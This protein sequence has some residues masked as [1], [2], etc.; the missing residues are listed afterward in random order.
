[1]KLKQRLKLKQNLR[2]LKVYS[3]AR[4]Y[5]S[6]RD[7]YLNECMLKHENNYLKAENSSEMFNNIFG[8]KTIPTDFIKDDDKIINDLIDKNIEFKKDLD[9]LKISICELDKYSVIAFCKYVEFNFHILK[10][11][12]N[13]IYQSQNLVSYVSKFITKKQFLQ[14]FKEIDIFTGDKKVNNLFY[15][16]TF[17]AVEKTYNELH[18]KKELRKLTTNK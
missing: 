2:I 16:K 3:L 15:K 12:N 11:N 8:A 18:I 10:I 17:L 4:F 7:I 9:Y 6:F 14:G 5:V 13:F 1:M